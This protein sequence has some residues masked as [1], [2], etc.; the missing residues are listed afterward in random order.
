[1]GGGGVI[2][3]LDK[4]SGQFLCIIASF[5]KVKVQNGNNIFLGCLY[6]KYFFGMPDVPDIFGGLTVDNV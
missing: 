2:T 3:K 1:M 4:F 6:F 5:L